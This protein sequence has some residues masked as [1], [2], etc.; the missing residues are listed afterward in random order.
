MSQHKKEL[1][2]RAEKRV[3]NLLSHRWTTIFDEKKIYPDFTISVLNNRIIGGA[4]VEY[5]VEVK[6]ARGYNGID[7]IGKFVISREEFNSYKEISKTQKVIF[8]IEI[9]PRGYHWTNYIYVVVP[10]VFIHERF[11]ESNPA[12]LTLSIWWA[13]LKGH[14]LRDWLEYV[15]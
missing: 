4:V 8:I 3:K 13:I 14:K 10:W 12:Q 1:G 7:R 11:I 5:A 6:T 2:E 9:R 15:C